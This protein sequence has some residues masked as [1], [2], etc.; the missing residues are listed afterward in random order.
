MS[1][2]ELKWYQNKGLIIILS[3]LGIILI[4]IILFMIYFAKTVD[5]FQVEQL[6][7][8]DQN[9]GAILLAELKEQEKFEDPTGKEINSPLL[10]AT[11][12]PRV[13]IVEFSDFNC[14]FSR[15]SYLIMQELN[16][17]YGE[18]IQLV[19]RNFPVT[20]EE[21]LVLSIAAKC[22]QEQ[23]FFPEMQR[24]LFRH[25]GNLPLE[26]L[27]D[28]AREIGMNMIEYNQCISA[29]KTE[30]EII[31]DAEGGVEMGVRGTPSYFING[32]KIEGDIP[33][34]IFEILIEEILRESDNNN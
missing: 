2:K 11:S 5:N 23:G 3:L 20:N 31:K 33:Y 28:L 8:Q 30:E 21:S 7:P 17:N 29:D 14:P 18:E 32:Y 22:A 16:K 9:A 19:F 24:E 4:L 12:S 1:N 10:G 26:R 27:P 13:T 15:E 34:E 6:D 25:Q